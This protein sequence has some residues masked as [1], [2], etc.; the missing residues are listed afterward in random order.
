MLIA[1]LQEKLGIQGG[2]STQGRLPETKEEVPIV[3]PK[4]I[5]VHRDLRSTL[6]EVYDN[7][8]NLHE[9]Q[10]GSVAI[11]R[12]F[13]ETQRKFPGLKLPEFHRELE[14]LND[15][16]IVELVEIEEKDATSPQFAIKRDG[17]FFYFV[18]W[19]KKS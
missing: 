12:L 15:E 6:K 2:H 1:A 10:N 19:K 13:T 17:R 18:R 11:P 7:L 9:Y 8:C 14:S 16:W 4:P 5:Q 3:A